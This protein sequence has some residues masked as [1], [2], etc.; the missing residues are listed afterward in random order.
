MMFEGNDTILFFGVKK[1][2]VMKKIKAK[3]R[4]SISVSCGEGKDI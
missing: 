1:K 4:I 3:M 2:E